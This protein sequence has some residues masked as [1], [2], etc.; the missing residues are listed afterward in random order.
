MKIVLQE[1]KV[2]QSIWIGRESQQV[3]QLKRVDIDGKAICFAIPFAAF[4]T[5]RDSCSHLGHSLNRGHQLS[6]LSDLP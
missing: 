5:L 3:R 1:Y 2:A 4:F 6:E